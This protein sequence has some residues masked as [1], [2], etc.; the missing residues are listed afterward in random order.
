MSNYLDKMR[1]VRRKG[2]LVVIGS[3]E[4]IGEKLLPLSSPNCPKPNLGNQ[5]E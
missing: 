2:D 1:C 5:N 3:E 4:K